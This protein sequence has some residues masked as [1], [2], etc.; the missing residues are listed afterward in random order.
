VPEPRAL[1][2]N[3][4]KIHLPAD[5]VFQIQLLLGQLVLKLG[6]FAIDSRIFDCDCHLVRNLAEELDLVLIECVF[7]PAR[8]GQDPKKAFTTNQR[9]VAEGVH[10]F[11]FGF[12][13]HFAGNRVRV[14][15]IH[16]DRLA[17]LESIA[18]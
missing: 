11:G 8:H 4:F 9:Q 1:A 10:S 2:Y 12:L 16:N 18:G 17:G 3:P 7:I 15:P 13:I 5:F 14:K 6:D